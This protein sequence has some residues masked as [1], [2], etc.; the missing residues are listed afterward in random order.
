MVDGEDST[1]GA[2]VI[3]AAPLAHSDKLV[4]DAAVLEARLAAI[5]GS[6]RKEEAKEAVI[7]ANAAAALAAA[8]AAAL[9]D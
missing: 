6:D 3:E 8:T 9:T 7:V 1:E 2:V 4:I 5:V